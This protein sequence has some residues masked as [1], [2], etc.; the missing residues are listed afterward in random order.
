MQR[1]DSQVLF[2]KVLLE[3]RLVNRPEKAAERKQRESHCS[4]SL[5]LGARW[6]YPHPSSPGL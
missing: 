3:L 4:Y 2:R 6:G 1:R 5:H